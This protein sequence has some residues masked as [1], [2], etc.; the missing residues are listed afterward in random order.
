[1]GGYRQWQLPRSHPDH[2]DSWTPARMYSRFQKILTHWQNAL[3]EN[4]HTIVMMDDN[5]DTLQNTSHNSNYKVQTL[6][7]AFIRHTQ[8]RDL[9]VHNFTPTRHMHGV[10]PS[11]IDH[12]T[13][14]CPLLVHS[15]ST[16]NSG[17]SDH[18]ILTCTYSTKFSTA[19]P[20]FIVT[21]DK[22]LLTHEALD[23]YVDN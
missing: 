20:S 4:K 2:L 18:S 15:T 10:S 11:C 13:S 5:I 23:Q 22:A 9:V 8:A 17:A 6:K 12:I 1:M 7:D 21:R 16:H 3:Q 19:K 14:N